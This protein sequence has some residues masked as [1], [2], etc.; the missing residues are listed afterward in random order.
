MRTTP[1]AVPGATNTNP[2]APMPVPRAHTA[3]M[4]GTLQ[5]PGPEERPSTMTKSLPDPVIL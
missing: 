2:S 3:R 4:S 1:G 5:S